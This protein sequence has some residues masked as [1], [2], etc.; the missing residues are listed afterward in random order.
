LEAAVANWFDFDAERAICSLDEAR[1]A[2]H[3]VQEK[4]RILGAAVTALTEQTPD[5]DPEEFAYGYIPADVS[6]FLD[7][8]FRLE[9]ALKNDPDFRHS[10]LPYR[11]CAFLDIGCGPGRN[12]FLLKHA[13]RFQFHKIAGFDISE[14]YIEHGRRQ[15]YLKDE[16]FV[17]DARTFDYG[18]YDVLYFYRLFHEEAEETVFEQRLIDTMK[19]GSFLIAISPLILESSRLLMRI[20]DYRRIFKRL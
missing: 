18:G 8:M 17:A 10:D 6:E 16:L 15:F 19:R 1:Q 9:T 2:F 3:R 5:F 14:A 4:A 13:N 12:V 11:P 7:C 20:D